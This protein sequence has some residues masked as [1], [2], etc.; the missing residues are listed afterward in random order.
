MSVM[1]MFPLGMVLL[2]GSVLP[3]HVFEPRY[4]QMVRDCLERD[5]PEFGVVLIEQGSEVGGGEVRR[6]VGTVARMVQVAEMP[7]GRYAVMAVGV[8]RLRVTAWLPDDPYPLAD[9]DLWPDDGDASPEADAAVEALAARVRRVMALA[10]EL[11]D[12]VGDPQQEVDDDPWVAVHQLADMA[13][14][15]VTD[16]FD[17][18]CAA[19]TDAR[20]AMLAQRLDD[21]EAL[22]QMRLAEG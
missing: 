4:R 14:V 11:G 21:V 2:P 3:L 12:T 8:A 7:D 5:E 20:I 19:N 18:L 1:P 6:M 17:V 15:G 16:R 22:Q 13:P 10:V 9:V